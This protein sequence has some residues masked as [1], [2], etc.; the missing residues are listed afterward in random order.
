MSINPRIWNSVW[1][2]I[3]CGVQNMYSL[4][5]FYFIFW[6]TIESLVN[7]YMFWEALISSKFSHIILSTEHNLGQSSINWQKI[8][9][10]WIIILST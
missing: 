5:G 6:F 4:L 8:S 7:I 9:T 1:D 3:S 10:F 2:C